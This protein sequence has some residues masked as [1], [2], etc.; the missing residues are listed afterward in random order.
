[1]CSTFGVSRLR[2]E[3]VVEELAV[4]RNRLPAVVEDVVAVEAVKKA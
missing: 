3:K 4:A 1:M 2:E